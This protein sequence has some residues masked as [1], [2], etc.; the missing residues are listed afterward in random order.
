MYFPSLELYIVS[1]EGV[2]ELKIIGQL[3]FFALT[4]AKSLELKI[5]LSSCL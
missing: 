2:A 4:I 5:N 1:T 3:E